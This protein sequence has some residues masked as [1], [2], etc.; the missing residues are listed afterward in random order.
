MVMS[1]FD[2]IRHSRFS[3]KRAQPNLV[4]TKLLDGD[5][6]GLNHFQ[7]D[8]SELLQ[9]TMKYTD[10]CANNFMAAFGGGAAKLERML[11]D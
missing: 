4:L 3:D 8:P 2:L 1:S 11:L 10:V 6:K 9:T 5:E 7:L